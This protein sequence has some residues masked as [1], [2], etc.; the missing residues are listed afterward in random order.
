MRMW[1]TVIKENCAQNPRM[2][3]RV[4]IFRMVCVSIYPQVAVI[5][6]VFYFEKNFSIPYP[7]FSYFISIENLA[8]DREFRRWQTKWT[9]STPILCEPP[10]YRA[11]SQGRSGEKVAGRVI[12]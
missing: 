10:E 3:S 1:K 8:G 12:A 4:K 9:I 5:P 7:S 6:P 2:K 11:G